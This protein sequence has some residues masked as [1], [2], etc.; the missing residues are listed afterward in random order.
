MNIGITG[1]QTIPPEALDHVTQEIKACI[2]RQIEPVVGFSN[3]AVGADQLFARLVIES[4]GTL[5]AIVPSRDYEGTFTTEPDLAAY[6]ALLARAKDVI[7]LDFP[8][9]TESAFMAG[10]DEVARRSDLVIAVWDGVAP[11]LRAD[12]SMPHGG[13]IDAVWN[14]WSMGKP[15]LNVWPR[16]VKR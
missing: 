16:G 14:A 5:A 2:Q 11:P 3:L 15:V 12:G 4:G 7:I 6:Q 9:P 1:H 8:G 10:G 13:T